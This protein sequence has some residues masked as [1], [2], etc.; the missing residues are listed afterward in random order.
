MRGVL[1]D[2]GGM[3]EGPF[4]ST[5]CSVH[6]DH[7]RW[8]RVNSACL[9]EHAGGNQTATC[10]SRDGNAAAETG[11]RSKRWRTRLRLL[12]EHDDHSNGNCDMRTVVESGNRSQVCLGC[13]LVEAPR[14]EP[15]GCR[16]FLLLLQ[17][18]YLLRIS[19]ST[20]GSAPS[21]FSVRC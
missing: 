7:G 19:H 9:A 1:I 20:A 11:H 13:K 21:F 8:R 6:K 16:S 12:C 4:P 18:R 3:K 15:S 14:L 17:Q 5:G 2:K 10:S